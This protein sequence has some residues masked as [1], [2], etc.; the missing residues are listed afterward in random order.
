MDGPIGWKEWN[1][2]I[3]EQKV[4]IIKTFKII[5]VKEALELDRFFVLAPPKAQVYIIGLFKK[6]KITK[7]HWDR[8]SSV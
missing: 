5:S 2:D 6:L 4:I 8:N 7:S 3:G 1:N